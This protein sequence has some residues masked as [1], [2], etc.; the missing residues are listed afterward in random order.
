MAAVVSVGAQKARTTE[1][2]LS[3]SIADGAGTEDYLIESDGAGPYI[4]GQSGVAARLDQYGNLIIAFNSARKGPGRLV[5]FDYSC[6]ID[7]ETQGPACGSTEVDP[8]TGLHGGAYVS[9]VCPTNVACANIQTMPVLT[10]QCVQLNWQFVDG[11]GR[12]WRNGFHRDRDLPDQAGTAYAVVSHPDDATWTVEPSAAA[13][14]GDNAANVARTFHVETVK[15]RWIYTDYGKFWLPFKM[16][17]T[18]LN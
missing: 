17:L 18:R 3:V 12:S 5:S 14:Q 4:D 15:S 13:C 1:V 11:Q 9:T 10:Q 7:P 8:P 2:R 6:P 16:T